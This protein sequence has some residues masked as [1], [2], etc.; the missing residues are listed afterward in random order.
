MTE[1]NPKDRSINTSWSDQV[2]IQLKKGEQF[3]TGL[4]PPRSRIFV[5]VKTISNYNNIR[6]HDFAITQSHGRAIKSLKTLTESPPQKRTASPR[7]I[8]NGLEVS[9]VSTGSSVGTS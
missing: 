5:D 8:E 1:L 7:F 6:G 4:S 9:S 2:P 3:R